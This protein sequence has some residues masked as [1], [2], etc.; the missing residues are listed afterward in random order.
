MAVIRNKYGAK[1]NRRMHRGL[2]PSRTTINIWVKAQVNSRL[3]FKPIDYTGYR[4]LDCG[5]IL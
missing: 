5:I 1:W 4:K 2:L 3:E